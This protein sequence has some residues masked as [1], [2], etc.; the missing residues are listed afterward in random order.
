MNNAIVGMTVERL[1]KNSISNHPS[2]IQKLQEHFKIKG[3]FE[4][5]SGGG[6]YGSKSDVRLNFDCGRHIDVNVKGFA[7]GFNQIART[8]VSK[9][10]EVFNLGDLEKEELERIIVE[11][12]K[13]TKND[14]FPLETRGKWEEFFVNC[15][16]EIVRWGF[17]TYWNRE[18]IALYDRKNSQVI[19]YSMKNVVKQISTKITFTKGGVSIGNCIS[20]QRKGGNGKKFDHIQKTSILHPGNNVQ[21][22]LQIHKFIEEFDGKELC[23]FNV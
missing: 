18:V 20:F 3:K 5:A 11:K 21:L 15:A 23:R 22:K 1:I 13:N 9:F 14:L 12:S 8:T 6:I 17:S 7:A 2:V 19:M 4:N 16:R 10:C